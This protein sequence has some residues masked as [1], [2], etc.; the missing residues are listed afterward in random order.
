[1]YNK[2][3]KCA[4][5][6]MNAQNLLSKKI[7][8]LQLYI[9]F[10]RNNNETYNW[11]DAT[12]CNVGC[13]FLA[14]YQKEGVPVEVTKN[15]IKEKVLKPYSIHNASYISILSD[16]IFKDVKDSIKICP[17]SGLPFSKLSQKLIE[18]GEFTATELMGLETLSRKYNIDESLYRFNLIHVIEYVERWIK[19]LQQQLQEANQQVQSSNPSPVFTSPVKATKKKVQRVSVTG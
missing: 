15:L 13:L 10:L 19:D 6:I 7:E 11:V 8:T 17:I 9:E 18:C 14:V 5:Y 2:F 16:Y 1:M 4:W 12:T 3:H